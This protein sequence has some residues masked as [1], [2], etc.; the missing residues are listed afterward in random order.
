FL[1]AEP[2]AVTAV[3]AREAALAT[4]LLDFPGDRAAVLTFW[5][6]PGH[7]ECRV[8]VR[9]ERGSAEARLPGRLN[10]HTADGRHVWIA[11]PGV[12]VSPEQRLLEQLVRSLRGTPALPRFDEVY[13][14]LKVWRAALRSLAEG[15]HP[16]SLG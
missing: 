11:P 14:T 16:Q 3:A 13:G 7:G 2:A 9:G 5:H 8:L 1:G 12:S 6:D 15:G 4:L 10:W